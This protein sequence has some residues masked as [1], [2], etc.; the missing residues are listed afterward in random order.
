MTQ[1]EPATWRNVVRRFDLMAVDPKSGLCKSDLTVLAMFVILAIAGFV[2]S[3]A[4]GLVGFFVLVL[5]TLIQVARTLFFG[6][7]QRTLKELW[8]ALRNAISGL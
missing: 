1:A 6:R 3:N 2:F 4:P 8:E 7:R 5:A